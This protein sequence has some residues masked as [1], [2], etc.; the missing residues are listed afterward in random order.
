MENKINFLLVDDI[1]SNEDLY[2]TYFRQQEDF[3]MC[4]IVKSAEDCLKMLEKN[5]NIHTI[6]MDLYIP[7]KPGDVVDYSK[8]PI[9][10]KFGLQ[11]KS[12]YEKIGILFFSSFTLQ[13]NIDLIEQTKYK[14]IG[15]CPKNAPLAAITSGLKMVSQGQRYFLSDGN[16]TVIKKNIMFERIQN[17][18]SEIEWMVLQKIGEGR[19]IQEIS[20]EM[21]PIN[22]KLNQ[23]R[24]YTIRG[25]IIEKLIELGISVGGKTDFSDPY[26]IHLTIKLGIVEAYEVRIDKK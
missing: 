1:Q 6:L 8:T 26:L 22:N 4:G 17:N 24:I 21:Q 18:L 23:R 10:L 19:T 13:N 12:K 20:Y 7:E 9:G 2:K 5:K 3:F 11:V 15:F 25:K 16:E 14:G